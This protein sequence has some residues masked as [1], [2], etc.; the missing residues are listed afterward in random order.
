MIS[1]KDSIFSYLAG[2]DERYDELQ[3]LVDDYDSNIEVNQK[4]PEMDKKLQRVVNMIQYRHASTGMIRR[5]CTSYLFKKILEKV[6]P[7]HVRYLC[8]SCLAE[9]GYF[10]KIRGRKLAKASN[11][12]KERGKFGEFIEKAKDPENHIWKEV[13]EVGLNEEQ[14]RTLKKAKGPVTKLRDKICKEMHKLL[15]IRKKLMVMSQEMETIFDKTGLVMT[16]IQLSRFLLYIDK[17]KNRKE[18]SVFEL[19]GVKR[20]GFKITKRIKKHMG[21]FPSIK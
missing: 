18:L 9:N 11:P 21:A 2:R 3:K 8:Y 10:Q 20:S 12:V 6:V 16:P 14:I 15:E 4:C 13:N 17:V 19:W 5:Q 7:S 1:E